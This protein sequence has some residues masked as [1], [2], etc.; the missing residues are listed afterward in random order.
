MFATG[1]NGSIGAIWGGQWGGRKTTIGLTVAGSTSRGIDFEDILGPP[2]TVRGTREGSFDVA[3]QFGHD[4]AGSAQGPSH[5]GVYAKAAFADFNPSPVKASVVGGFAGHGLSAGRQRDRWGVGFYDYDFSKTQRSHSGLAG[6]TAAAAEVERYIANPGQALAYKIGQITI[7]DLRTRA[8][9]RL[10][11]RFDV[12][13]FHAAVLEDGAVPLT[14]LTKMIERRVDERAAMPAPPAPAPT[15][16]RTVEASLFRNV[17]IFDGTGAGL[18][19]P[20]NVL[21]VGNTIKT[22]SRGNIPADP[23]LKLTVMEGGGSTLMSGLTDAHTHL[24]Q[25]NIPLMRLLTSDIG[26]VH[27]VASRSAADRSPE[28]FR[29]RSGPG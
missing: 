28:P 16:S 13:D 14:V 10:G 25:S 11:A 1:V 3:V 5:V 19:P 7:R 6:R 9:E 20:S 27:A 22:I 18:S 4:L 8:E 26:Y 24:T 2:G 17:R 29:P 23:A 15:A 12:R 21:V